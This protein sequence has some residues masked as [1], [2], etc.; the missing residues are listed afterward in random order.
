MSNWA[1][2]TVKKAVNFIG[3][4]EAVLAAE[5]VRG[6]YDGIICGHIHK[7]ELTQVGDVAYVNCGDWVESCTAIVEL[8][9][10]TLKLIDWAA[11]TRR[12]N[13]R[14][15]RRARANERTS[16]AER[17]APEHDLVS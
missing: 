17:T 14:K 4:Y 7:A 3:E 6:G 15:K 1:K 11:A 13:H 9:D 12:A 10:G 8:P 5:A 16:T 2:Q